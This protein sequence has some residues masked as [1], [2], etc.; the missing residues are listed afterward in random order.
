MRKKTKKKS[1]KKKKKKKKEEKRKKIEEE[2]KKE[3]EKEKDREKANLTP[4]RIDYLSFPSS[5]PNTTIK[6][7]CP[8]CTF[9]PNISL[10]L[11]SE[12]H[13]V[14]CLNIKCKY[15]YCCSNPK[16]TTLD[17]YISI[18]VKTHQ[19]N[20]YCEVHKE[21]KKGKKN[22]KNIKEPAFFSCEL[23]QKWMC[24]NCINEH[25]QKEN[26]HQFYLIQKASED[27]FQTN[28]FKHDNR[29]YKVY[30][31]I[32]E[33]ENFGYHFCEKC[34]L[35]QV[36]EGDYYTINKE[37]GLVYLKQVKE[38]MELGINYL[39]DYCKN[40]YNLLIKS[41]NKDKILMKKAKELYD[42]FLIRNRRALFYYQMVINTATPSCTNFCLIDN[43]LKLLQTKFD[44]VELNKKEKN[45]LLNKEEI[46]KVLKFFEKN[47]IVGKNEK[48]IED[49]KEFEIKE[50]G[51]IEKNI[52]K[53][54][55]N[56]KE[57]ESDKR[58]I[59][60]ILLNDNNICTCSN[61][62]YINIFHIKKSSFNGE[63]LLS[64]KAHEKEIIALDK[65][66]DNS[67]K[68]VTL[69]NDTIKIW[70]YNIDKNNKVT[71]IQCETSLNKIT[72]SSMEFLYVLNMSNS[73]SFFTDNDY[74]IILDRDYEKFFNVRFSDCNLKTLYQIVSNDKNNNVFI[75]GGSDNIICWNL[76]GKIDC[77]GSIKCECNHGNS[78]FYWKDNI[79]LV[80]GINI[81]SIVNIS[82]FKY[83][84]FIRLSS[85]EISCFLNIKCGILCGIGDTYN[86]SSFSYGIADKKLTKF[87]VFKKNNKGKIEY[88][89]IDKEFHKRGITNA[90][91]IDKDKF[92]CC[93]HYDDILKIYQIK[94]N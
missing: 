5:R 11:D 71:K 51:T 65:M 7:L 60:M 67:L 91:W 68:F 69:D 12:S 52:N 54:E 92:I 29:E 10:S 24:E 82:T 90:L 25:I 16:S 73:I 66:K 81:V 46:E 50:I 85:S 86:S 77:K 64:I 55:K 22:E 28:C 14:K 94:Q 8:K 38:L 48:K 30:A 41:I 62:G 17:D 93:F 26:D 21:E 42:K 2:S 78:I 63:H 13:Y 70:N 40:L 89:L 61:N 79:L 49:I 36:D 45:E 37:K 19:K 32:I 6:T 57:S 3:R 23:C 9:I 18:M 15:C 47:Y 1:K 34:D 53:I 4:F 35:P 88:F 43:I 56:K 75:V 33:F 87:V 74:V 83:E 27:N 80:G 59:G 72:E 84:Q 44:K 20:L 58:F 76:I 39:D 31:T